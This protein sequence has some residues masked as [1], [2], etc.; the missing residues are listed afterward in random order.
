[1]RNYTENS[2]LSKIGR[3]RCNFNML[4]TVGGE[5]SPCSRSCFSPSSY[6]NMTP[7]LAG[8]NVGTLEFRAAIESVSGHTSLSDCAH[9]KSSV[10]T[11]IFSSCCKYWRDSC[12]RLQG[13]S[14]NTV[15]HIRSLG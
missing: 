11:E 7:L 1:M 15:D 10:A 13:S 5:E 8:T 12:N 2:P 4:T 14:W 6:F 3:S 9:L